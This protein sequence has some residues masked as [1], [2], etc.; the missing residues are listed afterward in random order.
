MLG[1]ANLAPLL[2]AVESSLWHGCG[3]MLLRTRVDLP[4][5]AVRCLQLIVGE[6]FGDNLTIAPDEP[7]RPL[8]RITAAEGQGQ[9]GNY[10]GNAKK[11]VSIGFHTDGSGVLPPVTL[12]SMSCIRPALH[13]GESRLSDARSVYGNMSPA[14]LAVLESPLPRENPYPDTSRP[15]IVMAPVFDPADNGAFSYHP[16]RLRNGIT[17]A[18]GSLSHAETRALDEL[19]ARLETGAIELR[20]EAGDILM[21]DNRRIAHDRRSFVDDPDAPRLL[22]RLWIGARAAVRP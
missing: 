17:T 10:K 9:A 8:F 20:L 15:P 13:G 7:G 3:A 21:L 14:A 16:Q 12:L 19:D 4:S 11:R 5:D 2:R 18:R 6:A 1:E 22:E